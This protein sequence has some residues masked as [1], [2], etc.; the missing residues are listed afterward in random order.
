VL[1]F[2]FGLL[3]LFNPTFGDLTIIIWTAI[4]FIVTGLFNIAIGLMMRRS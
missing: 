1:T 4:A 2:I 3:I